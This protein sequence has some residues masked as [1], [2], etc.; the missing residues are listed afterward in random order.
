VAAL[1]DYANRIP[2][3]DVTKLAPLVVSC[4]EANDEVALRVLHREAEELAHLARLA[5]DRLRR[6]DSR[7]EWL[8]SWLSREVFCSTFPRFATES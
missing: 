6:A 7:P 2:S 3:P 8:R 4:A 1:V 5:I